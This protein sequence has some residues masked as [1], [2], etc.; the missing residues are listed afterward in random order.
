MNTTNRSSELERL[1]PGTEALRT[2][3]IMEDNPE[4]AE[5][6]KRQLEA[7]K[8]NVLS[9]EGLTDCENLAAHGC[10]TFIL[11]IDMGLGRTEEGIAALR[12]LKAYDSRIYCVLLT[13]HRDERFRRAAR[14]LGCDAFL[15]KSGRDLIS[16]FDQV[17]MALDR[18]WLGQ[19]TA[20]SF[21]PIHRPKADE[22]VRR[23]EALRK[24]HLDDSPIDGHRELLLSRYRELTEKDLNGELSEEEKSELGEVDRALESIEI[25]EADETDKRNAAG[26]PGKLDAA[27]DRIGELLREWKAAKS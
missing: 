9:A 8:Y 19:A 11:D 13:H 4:I 17:L 1:T 2:I 22:I 24:D 18:M 7:A 14:E 23:V 10:R 25:S 12:K 15:S 21:D 27:L 20:L 3:A 5:F 6:V 26:R 16:D